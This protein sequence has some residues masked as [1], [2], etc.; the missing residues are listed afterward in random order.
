MAERTASAGGVREISYAEFEDTVTITAD[1]AATLRETCLAAAGRFSHD[2]LH[3]D[4]FIHTAEGLARHFPDR[5]RRKIWAFRDLGSV[6]GVLAVEGLPV[7]ADEPTPKGPADEPGWRDIPV[8][9]LVQLS[10]MTMLGAPISYAEEKSGKLIQDVYPRAGY[11]ERQEN[12][13][14]V[15]LELHTEDGFLRTPPDYL[16]LLC[17]RADHDSRAATVA[18]GVRRV[19]NELSA[20]DLE[21]LRQP[22]FKIFFS[23]SFTGGGQE[24]W[25]GPIPVL[26]GPE[27]DPDLCVDLHGMA[28]VDDRAGLTLDRLRSCLEGNLIGAVLRRGSLLIID[29]NAA[30]HGRTGFVPRY[31]G[32]DRWLRRCFVTKDLRRVRTDIIRGRVLRSRGRSPA[33]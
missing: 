17:I 21:I 3:D 18:C 31:D 25:T 16:S 28:A 4:E 24:R 29:N 33:G 13:G 10:I 23:S 32:T 30:V 19:L 6:D 8:A 14:S 5:L 2:D 22:R 15:L 12:A 7:E 1:E 11:E 26:T 20:E 9:T 27:D